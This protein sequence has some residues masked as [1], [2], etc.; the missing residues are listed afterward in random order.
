MSLGDKT[1]YKAVHPESNQNPGRAP[2]HLPLVGC[3][4]QYR[5]IAGMHQLVAELALRISFYLRMRYQNQNRPQGCCTRR[6]R[7]DGKLGLTRISVV[8]VY[9]ITF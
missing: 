5:L 8:P 1:R 9:T 6:P 2:V 7:N 3:S 4:T